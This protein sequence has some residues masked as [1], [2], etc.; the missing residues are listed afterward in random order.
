[1]LTKSRVHLIEAGEDYFEHLRFA[2]GVGLMLIAAGLACIIHGLIPAVCTKTASRTV[3]ELRRLFAERH[4]LASVLEEAS[5]ALTLVGLVALTTPAW[6]LLLLS[7]GYPLPLLTAA[8][9]LA[10]PA[11]YLW[12]NPQ[13]ERVD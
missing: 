8:F 12:T 4:T 9:A 7:P 11:A 3:D 13:L 10:I 2:V 6:A 5:G 1:M